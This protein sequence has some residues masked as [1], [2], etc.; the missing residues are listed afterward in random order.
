[1]KDIMN[2]IE[3][4]I[5]HVSGENSSDLVMKKRMEF[6][7]AV[8]PKFLSVINE[9][10]QE[11]T[12]SK[13]QE[14]ID[15]INMINQV[16]R[17]SPVYIGY[18]EKNI[19][20]LDKEVLKDIMQLSRSALFFNLKTF[21]H[22]EKNILAEYRENH[23]DFDNIGKDQWK[24]IKGFLYGPQFNQ[25]RENL[26][27]KLLLALKGEIE[28]NIFDPNSLDH[29]ER[30]LSVEMSGEES[31]IQRLRYIEEN[32]NKILE[33]ASLRM[34]DFEQFLLEKTENVDLKNNN[35]LI[36]LEEELSSIKS[37]D[38]SEAMGKVIAI[39]DRQEK[40]RFVRDLRFKRISRVL[41]EEKVLSFKSEILNDPNLKKIIGS[42]LRNK[43]YI[44]NF[45]NTLKKT[46]KIEKGKRKMIILELLDSFNIG[47]EQKNNI[48]EFIDK[49]F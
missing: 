22:I 9:A 21:K 36:R 15:F 27:E 43:I 1:M 19:N 20:Q 23:P 42:N 32:K 24:G 34:D 2:G 30:F 16:V 5:A 31:R 46:E 17:L 45:L 40:I 25:E 11:A 39:K 49:Y 37:E 7:K 26:R 47:I 44:D 18:I 38:L 28:N 4:K 8:S 14:N 12:N 41:L 13:K 35:F 33:Y 6:F 48:S 10:E 3:K 29:V